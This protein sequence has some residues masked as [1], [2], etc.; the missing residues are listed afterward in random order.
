MLSLRLKICCSYNIFSRLRVESS[1][2][3][4]TEL[5]RQQSSLVSNQKLG[6][7]GWPLNND[8]KEVYPFWNVEYIYFECWS[9]EPNKT[10]GIKG[11]FGG[12]FRWDCETLT[13][14]IKLLK[15]AIENRW[16]KN[17]IE[18]FR[19]SAHSGGPAG[20]Q[21][22]YPEGFDQEEGSDHKFVVHKTDDPDSIDIFWP[23]PGGVTAGLAWPVDETGANYILLWLEEMYQNCCL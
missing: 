13:D 6:P 21:P 8:G 23:E 2:R 17:S 14:E 10:K 3:L 5:Q 4:S 7:L 19:K 16:G 9:S 11:D 12:I 1:Q 18:K 22:N 20:K 15:D